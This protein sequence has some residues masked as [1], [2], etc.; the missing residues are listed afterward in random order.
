M[1]LLQISDLHFG[2][3]YLPDVGEHLL[4]IAS[5]LEPDAIVVCG[6][7]TQRATREQF[8]HSMH[9]HEH[10]GLRPV[11]FHMFPRRGKQFVADS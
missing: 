11:G 10:D 4:R 5:A 1:T 9:Y 6:D 3:P 2:P 7:T 8:A